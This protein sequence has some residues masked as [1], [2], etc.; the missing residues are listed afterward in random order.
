MG[1][2]RQEYW[3]GV[4]L[5][6]LNNV[7][8]VDKRKKNCKFRVPYPVK[9]SFRN[10]EEIKAMATHSSILAWKIPWMEE[11]GRLQPMGLRRVGHD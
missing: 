2:S 5:P 7:L 8:H 4:P 10:E 6:S 11:L 9:I 3:S 1:F